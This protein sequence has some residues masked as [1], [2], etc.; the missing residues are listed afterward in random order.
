MYQFVIQINKQ[1]LGKLTD[2]DVLFVYSSVAQPFYTCGTLNIVGIPTSF[3]MLW[4]VGKMIYGIDWPR[5]L[6]INRPQS[7]NVLFDVH[8][9]PSYYVIYFKYIHYLK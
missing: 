8:N 3:C 2:F 5:Q 7:K 1:Y 6:L 9:Y 4:G